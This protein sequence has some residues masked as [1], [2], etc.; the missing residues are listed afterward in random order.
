[1]L[2]GAHLTP[3]IAAFFNLEL[4]FYT[5]EPESIKRGPVSR[6]PG[7]F[8]NLEPAIIFLCATFTAPLPLKLTPSPVHSAVFAPMPSPEPIKGRCGAKIK[9]SMKKFGCVM[10]CDAVPMKDRDRCKFHG[11]MS[12]RGLESP[13]YKGRGYSKD[14]PAR[15]AHRMERALNDPELT[16]LAHELALLDARIGEIFQKMPTGESGQAWD[17]MMVAVNNLDT[18]LQEERLDDAVF[19]IGQAKKAI[20]LSKAERDGWNEIYGAISQRRQLADT[21]RKREEMLSGNM[22]VRQ[23]AVLVTSIQTAILEEV[24]DPAVRRQLAWRIS[25]L[26]NA[27]PTLPGGPNVG[28]HLPPPALEPGAFAHISVEDVSDGNA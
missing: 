4:R 26:L 8:T 13:H 9:N 28:M 25:V 1:M 24:H 6:C 5:F 18:A 3:R 27:N 15:L 21:E 10:Y 22:T 11:G 7:V 23:A 2:Q 12:P 14:L 17:D 16:S 19:W 20:R